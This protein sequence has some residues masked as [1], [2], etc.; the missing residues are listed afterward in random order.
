MGL[1]CAALRRESGNYCISSV[2]F[3]D[4]EDHANHCGVSDQHQV[5]N[6]NLG[7][8]R[9]MVMNVVRDKEQSGCTRFWLRYHKPTRHTFTRPQHTYRKD[10]AKSQST[11]TNFK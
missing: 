11:Y 7:R 1:F 3:S 2:S 8:A 9:K 10:T 5:G 4:T 6:L